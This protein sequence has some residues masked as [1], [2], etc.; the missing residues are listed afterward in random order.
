MQGQTLADNHPYQRNEMSCADSRTGSGRSVLALYILTACSW[1]LSAA[2]SW[3]DSQDQPVTPDTARLNYLQYYSTCKF[4]NSREW[5][6]RNC[7]WDSQVLLNV[8]CSKH[9]CVIIVMGVLLTSG[10]YSWSTVG[11]YASSL[12]LGSSRRCEDNVS[13][14]VCST[15]VSFYYVSMVHDPN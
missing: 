2:W 9:Y 12:A 7:Q 8:Q 13:C 4:Y 6:N 10:A 5:N 14:K 1:E 11:L 15:L 3:R